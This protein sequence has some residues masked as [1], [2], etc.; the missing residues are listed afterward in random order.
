MLGQ[1]RRRLVGLHVVGVIDPEH[2]ERRPVR[3][4]LAVPARALSRR[5]LV[6][7]EDVLGPEIARSQSV[8]AGEE[9]R[10]LVDRDRGQPF[11]RRAPR[12][13]ERLV[14]RRP[15]VAPHR[16]VARHRLV[17]PLE[18]DDVLLP[19]ERLDDG[20]LGE[21]TDHVEV[22]RSDRRA[23]RPAQVVDPGFD[24]LGGRS[25]RDEH[26]V[27]VGGLVLGD[28]AVGAARQLRERFVRL[29][30]RLEDRLGEMIAPRDDALH[31]V[32]LVLH[33]TEEH[34]VGEIDHAR[35]APARRPEQR[36]LALGGAL[37]DVVG[38]SEIFANECCFVLVERPLEMR[39][40]EAVLDV[41][42]R[43]QRQLGDAAQDERLIRGLLRVLPEHH[44]PAGV[45]RAVDVVVPAVHVERVLGERPRRHLQH[46]R[47][48]LARRVIVL[49]DAVHHALARRVVDDAPAAD[50]VRD[51]AALRGVLALGFDGD[52]AAPEDVQL[53]LGVRL[54]KE[55]AA[56]RGRRD[57]IEDAAVGDP[58][59]RVVGDELVAVGRDPNAR[60]PRSVV[61]AT[62]LPRRGDGK[63]ESLS[64][65][66]NC[67]AVV[68]RI[69][70]P[71]GPCGN[72]T[73]GSAPCVADRG[74]SQPL[75][76][77]QG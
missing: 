15:D 25:E 34:R 17:G 64:P 20:G 63:T 38:R 60:I 2:E 31:V 54:L 41:H 21:G 16:V 48:A 3:R 22:N 6:R 50:R 73:N 37:D 74:Q 30:E 19:G 28:E 67:R 8:H 59:F 1:E 27:G 76:R 5:E 42:P 44:D 32:L 51:C 52:R 53:A 36:P 66:R 18:D 69:L 58:R 24:V 75:P 13:Q 23:A 55:L 43:R 71:R 46:H 39:G 14:E 49:L 40:E 65:I 33:G 62:T 26:R 56:F 47:R 29:D 12:R 7:A 61:H 4:A 77:L 11:G 70:P 10:H 68:A 35:H 9:P 72:C 45:E 57:G